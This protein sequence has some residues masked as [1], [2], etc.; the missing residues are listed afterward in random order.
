MGR[1]PTRPRASPALR[2]CVWAA[3]AA[4]VAP[5]LA[6][7]IATSAGGFVP[8]GH[9]SHDHVHFG[10]SG[11]ATVPT[12]HADPVAHDLSESGRTSGE[13]LDA[14][15]GLTGVVPVVAAVVVILVF[16]ARVDPIPLRRIAAALAS[17]DPPPRA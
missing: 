4:L 7:G 10:A 17:P 11:S 5:T 6:I 16:A 3:L 12:G 2:A 1:S 15:I 8:V 9:E 13:F 14:G